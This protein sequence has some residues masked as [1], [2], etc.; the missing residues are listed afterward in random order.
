MFVVPYLVRLQAFLG[1]LVVIPAK[2]PAGGRESRRRVVIQ[3][4]DM[5]GECP[6][7]VGHAG[8]DPVAFELPS[9]A[10]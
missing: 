10:E 7:V 3:R 8:M 1:Q 2:N 5:G 6:A 9:L 4:R